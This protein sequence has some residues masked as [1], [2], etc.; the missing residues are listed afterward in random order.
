MRADS[1]AATV[2]RSGAMPAVSA[3]WTERGWSELG[4]VKISSRI[5]VPRDG[6]RV[7]AAGGR[8]AGVAWDQ[9][10]GIELVEISVDGGGWQPAR[11]G[12]V[13]NVD[14]WL[15]F[16]DLVFIDPVGTGYSHF[17]VTAEP[18]RKQVFAEIDRWLNA[19]VYQTGG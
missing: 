14:T 11:L 2:S 7:A 1:W 6:G 12:R 8:V 19:F 16:T 13:P 15:D 4:P 3:Y 10:T 9:H 17:V 5:D 18:V